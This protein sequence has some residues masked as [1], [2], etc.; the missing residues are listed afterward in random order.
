M[1]TF[2]NEGQDP[3][4]F[5]GVGTPGVFLDHIFVT[6]DLTVLVHAVQPVKVDGCFPSDHMPIVVD[7]IVQD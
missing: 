1:S 5:K 4:A 3:A 6:K 2:T 7:L